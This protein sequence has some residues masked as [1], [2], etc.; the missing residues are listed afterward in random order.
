MSQ[1]I[2]LDL[3]LPGDLARFKLPAGVNER[4]SA[5]L[6]KQDAGEEL[7]VQERREAEGLVDL[8]DTLTYLG[9]KAKAA[10]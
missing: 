8:A 1:A 3:E 5:L 2:H 6:D 7:T 10:A 4:L 9:L